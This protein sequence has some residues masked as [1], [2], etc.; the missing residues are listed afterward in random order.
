MKVFRNSLRVISFLF[1]L[2]ACEEEFTTIDSDIINEDTATNFNTTSEKFE[3]LSY[4]EALGPVQTNGLGTN[5]L[6]VFKDN[7]Y[8][9]TTASILTQ[10]SSSLIAP[11]FGNNVV[12]DS[13]VLSIP[14]SSVNTGLDD[15]GIPTFQLQSI[16]PVPDDLDNPNYAPI[17]LSIFE[18][19]YFLRDFDPNQDFDTPQRY[20]SNKSAS[21]SEQISEADLEFT[22]LSYYG[23]ENNAPFVISNE[24]IQLRDDE[25]NVS[26]T[27][28]PRIRLKFRLNEDQNQDFWY[29]K[30]IAQEGNST[31]SNANNFNNHFRGIYIKAEAEQD[32]GSLIVLNL[33]QQDANITMFY[34]RDSDNTDGEREQATYTLTFGPSRINFLDND[35]TIDSGNET[36]GDSQLHIKGGEG[37]IASITLFNGENIDDDDNTDNTFET[38]RNDYINV[39]EDGEFESYKRLINEA[40]LVFYV[41]QTAVD[42]EEPNRLYLYNKTNGIPLTDYSEDSRNNTIPLISIPNHLGILERE[43]IE[44]S[45]SPGIKYTMK[46]TSHIVNML[47]NN[48]EN[49]EL[50]LAVSGNVNV[51]ATTPQFTVQ[52]VDNSNETVP[53]SALLTPRGTI[54]HGSAST[55]EDKRLYLEIFY[56]CLDVNENC[57]DN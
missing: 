33:D 32:N 19:N 36:E 45:D 4:T 57:E 51:E 44:D 41:D 29:Q 10:V 43:D 46:I 11:T 6:G 23:D 54:L 56:T 8:G 35:F 55:L 25:G 50:G 37:A 22:P 18:N 47:E 17:Q 34:T 20:F 49:V 38:W 26:Q 31:L 21:A 53:A 3:V 30:I 28:T 7:A 9:Q 12:L 16:L 1:V 5:M 48:T 14:Y 39:N 2:V 27:L 52:T 15:D 13:V 42:G 24:A 40:N